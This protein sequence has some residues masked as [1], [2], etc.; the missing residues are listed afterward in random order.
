M[1]SFIDTKVIFDKSKNELPG[2]QLNHEDFCGYD[3]TRKKL[4]IDSDR[5]W[6]LSSTPDVRGKEMMMRIDSGRVRQKCKQLEGMEA[7]RLCIYR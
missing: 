4:K 2:S 3:N 6:R 5:V 7:P 1:S